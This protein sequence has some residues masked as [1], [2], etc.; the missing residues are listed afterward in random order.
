MQRPSN[1][2]HARRRQRGVVLIV[3]LVMLV[4][5]G[6]ASVAIMRNVMG[7]D[8]VSENN[9]RHAQAMQAAQAALRFCELS[10]A[11]S[12]MVP[13]APT[14]PAEEPWRTFSNWQGTAGTKAN[15]GPVRLP[16]DFMN[17]TTSHTDRYGDGRAPLPQCMAQMRSVSGS[18]TVVLITARGF[19]DNYAAKSNGDTAAGAVVWLQSIIQL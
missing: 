2:L 18:G 13:A 3:A 5:I 9:R 7:N 15:G 16:A 6:L 12:T 4:V 10:V 8:L 19:S 1:P 17:S 11:S 14:P